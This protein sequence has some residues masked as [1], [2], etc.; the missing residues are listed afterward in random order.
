MS[1]L[2]CTNQLNLEK[3]CVECAKMDCAKIQQIVSDNICS[4]LISAVNLN[5]Q[6]EVANNLCVPGTINAGQISANMIGGNSICVQSGTINTLCVDN[7]SVGNFVPYTNYRATINYSADT[8]YTLGTNL[9]FDNI[10]DDPNNNISLTP[11]TTYT[12]PAA[13]YYMLT[14]KVNITNLISTNGPILGTPV[15]SA[16]VYVNGVLV[17]E[18]FNPFLTFLNSQKL[19]LSSLITLQMGDVVS[20]QYN[21]LAGNGAAVIGTVDIQGAGIEDGNSL[22]KIIFMSGLTSGTGVACTQ[23]PTVTIPCSPVMTPCQPLVTPGGANPCD[24]CMC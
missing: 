10:V 24:S 19:I 16:E 2:C 7:L 9:S 1:N 12:A 4:Q 21:V 17:R 6:N 15:A 23:C 14:Y 5:V 11:F 22:F 8:I 3:L 20:M 18:S 13:G